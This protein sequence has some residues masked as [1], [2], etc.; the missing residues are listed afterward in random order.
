MNL[1]PSE[2]DC[3]IYHHPCSDGFGAAY[4]AWKFFQL[5][6]TKNVEFLPMNIG[7]PPPCNLEGKNLLLLDYS[8]KKEVVLKLLKIVKKLLIID[9]HK[10]AYEDLQDLP[11]E[12]KFFDMNRS[13][14]MLAWEYFFP[15]KKISFND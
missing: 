4:C 11:K 8:Y 1:Q 14:A 5:N 13:G 9:H 10:S 7:D 2:V 6:Y 15:G 12:Y 3:I